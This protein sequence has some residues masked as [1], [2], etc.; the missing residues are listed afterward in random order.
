MCELLVGLPDVNVLAVVDIEGDP[1]EISVETCCVRPCCAGCGR[2]ASVKDRPV[3]TLVDLPCFGRPCRLRWRKFRWGCANAGCS[4]GSWTEQAPLIGSPRLAMTDRAGRW[5]TE[6][7]GRWG[8]TA[9]EI[10]VELATDWHTINDTV[11]AY[12]MA[13]VDDPGRVGAVTALGL[14]ETLFF[15]QGQWRTQRWCTSIVDVAGGGLA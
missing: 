9:N 1:L 13:L 14:D 15:R 3:V 4:V 12:G 7:V 10:A 5:V 8:R 2:S 6:Q 11:I